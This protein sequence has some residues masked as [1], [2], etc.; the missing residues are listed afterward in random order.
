[1]T[2]FNDLSLKQKGSKV[3]RFDI[4]AAEID[5]TAAGD[6]TMAGK[7]EALVTAVGAATGEHAGGLAKDVADIESAI[8][9]ASGDDAGG[10]LKDVADLKA[11][12][13][14][15]ETQDTLVYDVADIV[16]YI[17]EILTANS[18]TDPRAG[19]GDG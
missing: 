17:G 13:G 3:D 8:G 2:R 7:V 4:L 12:V 18:L 16:T 10:I 15:G 1:M 14:D 9:A 6:S 5:A 19:N 11:A